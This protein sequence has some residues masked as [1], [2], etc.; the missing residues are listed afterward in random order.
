MNGLKICCQGLSDRILDG[1][2]KVDY[3]APRLMTR[4]GKTV[5]KCPS[6]GKI[7]EWVDEVME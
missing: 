1:S 2:I 3:L 7:V 5:N 6:C 4:D